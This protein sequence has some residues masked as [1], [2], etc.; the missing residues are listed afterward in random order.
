MK[1]GNVR[2]MSSR[3]ICHTVLVFVLQYVVFS[4]NWFMLLL[5]CYDRRGLSKLRFLHKCY[6]AMHVLHCCA[7]Q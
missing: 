3:Y 1:G 7:I 2:A 4:L 5:Q 6:V